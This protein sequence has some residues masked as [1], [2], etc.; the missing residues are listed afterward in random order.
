MIRE[1]VEDRNCVLSCEI[2]PPKKDSS[3][4]GVLET[5]DRIAELDPAFI[6]VTY[7]AGGSNS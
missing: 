1:N 6:S 3:F 2:F 7:G 5:V 4:P